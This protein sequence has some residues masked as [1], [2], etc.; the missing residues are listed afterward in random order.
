MAQT[1][2]VTEYIRDLYR[3]VAGI[4]LAAPDER[5][6]DERGFFLQDPSDVVW[7]VVL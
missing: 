3:E 2:S 6:T 7:P 1:Y 4:D 5:P